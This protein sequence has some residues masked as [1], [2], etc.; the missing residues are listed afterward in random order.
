M[1]SFSLEQPHR[2]S[3]ADARQKVQQALQSLRSKSA[4]FEDVEPDWSP[5]GTHC[6]FAGEGF[7]GEIGND[8][9]LLRVTMHLE[10]MMGMFR[11]VVEQKLRDLLQQA[12][13]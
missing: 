1:I 10:G 2:L 12:L 8:P 11:P 9:G 7:A 3:V 5:D 13:V 4:Y 6:R